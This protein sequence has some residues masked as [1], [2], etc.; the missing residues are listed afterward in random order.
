MET[1]KD[2]MLRPTIMNE[3]LVENHGNNL[4]VLPSLLEAY[5][6]HFPSLLGDLGSRRRSDAFETESERIGNHGSGHVSNKQDESRC[7][8]Y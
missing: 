4:T 6:R 8:G 5:K 3:G 2:S 1:L 7:S